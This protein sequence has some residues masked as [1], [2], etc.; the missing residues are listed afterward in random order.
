LEGIDFSFAESFFI[1]R[2]GE[3][4]RIGTQEKYK[5]YFSMQKDIK[6]ICKKRSK[7]FAMALWSQGSHVEQQLQN[8]ISPMKAI[9]NTAGDLSLG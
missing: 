5:A 3:A 7:V 2:L 4:V 1:L 6:R 8:C 9:L